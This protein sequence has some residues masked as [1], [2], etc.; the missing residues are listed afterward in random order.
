M[1]PKPLGCGC[2]NGG[3]CTLNHS[4]A[5]SCECPDGY[6]GLLCENYVA[7]R[8]ISREPWSPA[9]VV[10]PIVLTILVIGALGALYVFFNRR[11]M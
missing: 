3:V 2:L 8:I 11:H 6:S 4:V 10:V 1:K 5:L 7:K 9:T